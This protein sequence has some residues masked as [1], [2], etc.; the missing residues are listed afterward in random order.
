MTFNPPLKNLQMIYFVIFPS[1]FPRV[2]IESPLHFALDLL[3]ELT[4]VQ[5]VNFAF[6]RIREKLAYLILIPCSTISPE[7]HG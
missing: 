3:E 1:S 4:A 6:E 7:A 2:L 5:V